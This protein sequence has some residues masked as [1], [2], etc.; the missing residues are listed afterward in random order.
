[1]RP[2]VREFLRMG[3]VSWIPAIVAIAGMVSGGSDSGGNGGSSSSATYVPTGQG[4]ADTNWQSIMSRLMGTAG[5]QADTLTP[6]LQ[7]AFGN[8]A[9]LYQQLQGRMGRY[10]G[11]M[12]NQGTSLFG[13]ADNLHHAGDDLYNTA[14]DPEGALRARL[15]QQTTDNSRAATSARGIGMSGEA[16]GLENQALSNFNM[17]WEDRQLGRQ[18]QGLQGAV[19]AYDAAGRSALGGA[20][21]LDN[22]TNMFRGAGALPF[23][24]SDMFS[25]SMAG[26]VYDP[27]RNLMANLQS[28]L[29]LGQ[30]ATGQSF[31][32]GQTNMNNLVSGL[33]SANWNSISNAFSPSTTGS[34][35]SSTVDDTGW[36]G[37]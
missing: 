32:Q 13:A 36:G 12:E 5:G 22:S 26:G 30:S 3:F 25:G 14:K 20:S 8:T 11:Y 16:A 2:L 9:N 7:S 34:G 17:D 15:Q 27:M 24:L 23:Q 35:A 31:G 4:Q 10:G 33:T 19:G 28:Y 37:A 29:G 18:T 6:Y 21:L 1:M